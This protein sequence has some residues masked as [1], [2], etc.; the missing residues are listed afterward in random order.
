MSVRARYRFVNNSQLE[1][2]DTAS[3]ETLKQQ[4]QN[5]QEQQQRKLLRR[6]QLQEEK[7]SR[8]ASS[9]GP[10]SAAFGVEDHLDLKLS[11]PSKSGSFL[12]EELVDHLNNQIRELKDENGRLYKL[13]SERD[14][15]L[16]QLR[17][18]KEAEKI[19][20]TAGVTNETAATKIV[21]LS[22]KVRELTA[23]L[24]SEK[25]KGKQLGKKCQ[26]LQNKLLDS[27]TP[28]EPKSKK[29]N[30]NQCVKGLVDEEQVPDEAEA[31]VLQDKLRQAEAKVT[32]FRNQCL[33]LRQELKVA[34]K[35]LNQ[36]IGDAVNIQSLLN[37]NSNWRGRAQQ[38]LTLQ[39]KVTEL[40]SKVECQ[41]S[42]Y[43]LEEEMMGSRTYRKQTADGRQ[44]DQLKKLERE[45]KEA[46]ERAAAEVQALE[47]DNSTLKQKL[48]A[49]KARNKVLSNEVKAL[50]QQKQTLLD[51]GHHDDE[52]ITALMQQLQQL[53]SLLEDSSKN[54]KEKGD[55]QQEKLKELAMKTQQ[56]NNIVEQ[57][58][59]IVTEKEAKVKILEEEVQQLKLNHIQRNQLNA[60]G[61]LFS[62]SAASGENRPV[63]SSGA[64]EMVMQSVSPPPSRLSE[65]AQSSLSATSH[66]VQDSARAAS[67]RSSRPP[68]TTNMID[69]KLL[70]ELQS[71]CQEYRTLAQVATVERDKL[72]ELVQLLQRR[73]DESCEQLSASQ[74]ELMQHKRKTVQLEKQLGKAALKLDQNNSNKLGGK[75][76]SGA[77]V[78]GSVSLSNLDDSDLLDENNLEEL[79]ISLSIQKD[80]NEALK[81]ALQ[82]TLK[83]KEEDLRMYTEMM[84]ETKKVFLQALRQHKQ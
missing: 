57:L 61:A 84:E 45:R 38:I 25:T 47:E 14:F 82:S 16:R 72:T 83:A 55:R 65:R 31:K 9:D 19:P 21:E 32:E 22:K 62:Q 15:E 28:G 17:K 39:K 42:D 5:L 70:S 78:I 33:T 59:A 51:K 23:E 68:S 10:G 81:A 73:L 64:N 34:Q 44:R 56:D 71:E 3:S 52:L 13:L 46:Q 2:M 4:F 20:V 26:E 77:K 41:T 53:K 66:Q 24:E 35:V 43:D 79:Q 8:V 80:E 1:E 75:K 29:G 50:K 30:S 12:S 58:K 74:G 37:G 27:H 48:D 49:S 60:V 54:Q 6:K 63:T 67:R 11:D 36:E 76:K 40:K 18:K 7:N 69:K